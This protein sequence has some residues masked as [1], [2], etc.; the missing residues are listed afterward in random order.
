MNTTQ[1][2]DLYSQ[3]FSRHA[4]EIFSYIRQRNPI[5]QQAG[6]DGQTPIWFVSRFEDVEALLKDDRHFSLDFRQAIEADKIP[7][8]RREDKMMDM[9]NHHL[10][11]KD[12]EDH[13]RLR[14]LVSKAFTPQR[15]SAMRPRIQAIADQLIDQIQDQGHMDLVESYAFPLPITVIAELLGIP[16]EDRNQFRSWS[17]IFVRP[18][19][20]PEAQAAYLQMVMAFVG[21]LQALFAARRRAPKDDLISALLAAEDAG[22]RLTVE[23]LFSMVVLLIVAGHETTVT[24]IGNA[25]MALLSNPEVKARLIQHPEQMPQAIEEFLRYDAPV[26]RALTRFVTEDVELGGHQFRRGDLVIAIL[27]SANRDE[28]HFAEPD[29]LKIDRDNRSHLAFGRGVHFCL[30]APLARLEGEIAINT[31]LRRLPG[32]YLTVPAKDLEYRQVPLFHAYSRIPVAW[33]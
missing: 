25:T 33:K 20:T 5:M 14:A 6:I 12:G 30:G 16:V 2:Y 15:I 17:D 23:E 32:L 26:N 11:T 29:S 21:Y 1:T 27:G 3:D 4:Y 8:L 7:N 10:L 9:V 18:A 13:R 28:T 24:L 19:I 22:D 31:L